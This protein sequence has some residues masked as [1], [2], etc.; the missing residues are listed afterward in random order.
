MRER[1]ALALD[2][3]D[4]DAAC[5]LAARLDPWFGIVKIGLELFTTAGPAAV[6]ALAA[7]ER[8]LFLDLKLHD[9]P[10][11][12]ARAARVAG[13]L[14]VSFLTLHCAGG[15]DMVRAGAEALAEGAAG[16]GHPPP[17]A[18]GVTVLTS[19]PDATAFPIRLGV[20]MDGGCQGVVC[21]VA[22]VAR[23]KAAASGLL[24][25]VPGIR[26]PGSAAHDQARVGS[27]LA[28][29]EAGADVL[30]VGRAVTASDD[31]EGAAATIA[32]VVSKAL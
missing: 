10:T 30:V 12:V 26:L 6:E 21:S 29:L 7:P 3:D 19:E 20:A 1:L 13:R 32:E 16:A 18:L 14:G 15:I 4:L 22:E 11:T 25:V 31:P 23:V 8:R 9:I 24:T 2:V 28:A 17:A 5:R 27:P